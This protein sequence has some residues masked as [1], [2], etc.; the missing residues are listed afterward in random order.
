M[1]LLPESCQANDEATFLVL[2]ESVT[3]AAHRLACGLLQ[4]SALAE[5]AVQEAAVKAWQ[6]LDLHR[7][8]TFRSWFLSIVANQCRDMR[9]GSWWQVLQLWEPVSHS[10]GAGSEDDLA[11][12][13]VRTAVAAL[14][15]QERIV[16]I[17]Y[18]YLDLPWAEVAAVCGLSEAGARTRFYRALVR[19]RPQLLPKEATS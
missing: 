3:D 19:L 9:R 5:D 6:H 8:A 2:L 18:S 11:K 12:L 4:D 14:P 13:A 17:L 16:L 7:T 15:Y 10:L 1:D